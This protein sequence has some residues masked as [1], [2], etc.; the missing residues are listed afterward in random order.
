MA[1]NALSPANRELFDLLGEKGLH[2]YQLPMACEFVPGCRGCQAFLCDKDCKNDSVRVCLSPALNDYGAS[3]L[4]R[5][6]VRRLHADNGRVTAI[7]C[8]WRG[9]QIQLRA[10]TVVLAAGALATPEI[11]LRSVSS[12]WPQ[13][14]ANASGMVG[15]NLMR[16]CIDLYALYPKRRPREEEHVKEIA[17][18]DFYVHEG[19]KLGSVQSFG[20][21]PPARVLA[22][23]I[24]EQI[25]QGPLPVFA[26]AFGLLKPLLRPLL[27][28]MLKDSLLVVT[29]LED[30]PQ[31]S[32]RVYPVPERGIAVEYHLDPSTAERIREFRALMA[33]TLSPMK[34]RILKQAE[35]NER[36]AHA[37]GTCRMG[38]DAATSVL[39]RY[40]RA[41]D[42]EN[43][44]VVDA[45]FFPSSGGINPSLTIAANALRVA[46]HLTQDGS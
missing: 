41:H 21:L 10:K 4:D 38:A 34:Y 22:D 17:F 32:N 24:Q 11:L 29:T 23:E 5:C 45:S 9:K 7:D 33:R 31:A 28:R 1:P 26:G 37:C 6:E 25:R 40:N 3:L 16:H 19:R 39:D 44:Y 13:G 15:R 36:I 30:L 20:R 35:N 12:R 18:N 2:P 8:D 43:L 46:A 42:L 14:V 27:D